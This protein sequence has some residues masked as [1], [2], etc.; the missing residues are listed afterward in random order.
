[1]GYIHYPFHFFIM[2]TG[3]IILS[4]EVVNKVLINQPFALGFNAE[5]ILFLKI[6][7]HNSQILRGLNYLFQFYVHTRNVE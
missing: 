1:M 3:S 7:I 5:R 2:D 6:D 4:F